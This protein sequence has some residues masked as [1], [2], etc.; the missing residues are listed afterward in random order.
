MGETMR[1]STP[2]PTQEGGIEEIK[3]SLQPHDDLVKRLRLGYEDHGATDRELEAAATIERISAD[4]DKL[5]EDLKLA[6]WSDSEECKLLTEEN[7]KAQA[8]IE[9]LEGALEK[10]ASGQLG[11]RGD[12]PG[13]IR[14]ARAA[15]GRDAP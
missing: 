12:V 3:G 5:R 1:G 7:T 15:L 6:V 14:V 11:D 4:R 9:A 8:R 2:S 13:Y 10:I